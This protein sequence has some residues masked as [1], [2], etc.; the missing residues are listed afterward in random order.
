M[1]NRPI[2]YGKEMC[3]SLDKTGYRYCVRIGCA[4]TVVFFIFANVVVFFHMFEDNIA[5]IKPAM[6][7]KVMTIDGKVIVHEKFRKTILEKMTIT[8]DF[9]GR[10]GNAM[11]Q[12]AFVYIQAKKHNLRIVLRPDPAIDLLQDA[13][14]WDFKQYIV[15][16]PEVVFKESDLFSTVVNKYDC[17]FDEEMIKRPVNNTRYIGFFQSWQ[18][19]K[20]Y[21]KEIRALFTLKP[22]LK[23]WAAITLRSTVQ[24]GIYSFI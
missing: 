24:V 11:F 13:F 21:E 4:L 1:F 2:R 18:Y 23:E 3:D 6:D 15:D 16:W 22:K 8:V 20:S 14:E 7:F 19:F 12:F 17:A 9:A 5:S 10:L